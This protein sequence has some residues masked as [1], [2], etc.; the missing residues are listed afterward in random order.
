M[1]R[2]KCVHKNQKM[3]NFLVLQIMIPNPTTNKNKHY[4]FS[5]LQLNVK[6][7]KMPILILHQESTIPITWI[8]RPGS[9]R[10]SKMIQIWSLRS[11]DLVLANRDLKMLPREMNNSMMT[12]S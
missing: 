12:I 5:N 4:L 9:L 10:R 7:S 2:L 6:E 11:L 3:K 1:G 8:L